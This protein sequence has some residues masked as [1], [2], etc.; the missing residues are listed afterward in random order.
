MKIKVIDS[1]SVYKHTT[2]NNKV[3]IGITSVDVKQRW[4]NGY[5]HNA[6]FSNA[7]QK[8]GWD[9]IKHEIL[10]NGLTKEEAC[11]KE[12]ELIALYKSNQKGFGYN[13]S[14]GGESHEGCK[15]SEELRKKLS[16]A[17]KGKK[18]SEETKR[19]MAESRKGKHWKLSEGARHNISIAKRGRPSHKK[20][21]I[22]GKSLYEWSE[23]IGIK[24]HTLYARI[25]TYKWPLE[26]ALERSC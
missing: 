7:I 5:K 17:H 23:E 2:P 3:Y 16:D 12:I 19:K 6:Y 1:Y 10:F 25:F 8:Y 11:Q 15:A 21:I 14:S 26:K 4:R 20:I 22:D 24:E 18:L 9:N 13:L